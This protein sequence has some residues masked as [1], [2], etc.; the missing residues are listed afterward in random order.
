MGTYNPYGSVS[1]IV[2]YS[3]GYQYLVIFST[4][5]PSVP[6]AMSQTTPPRDPS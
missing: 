1:T 2:Q 4:K 6:C 5:G 3:K